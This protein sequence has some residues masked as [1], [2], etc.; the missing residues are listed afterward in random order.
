[1]ILIKKINEAL[2]YSFTSFLVI[3]FGTTIG[4]SQTTTLPPA[5]QEAINKAHGD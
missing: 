2:F 1:M 3:S 5:A 4:Y